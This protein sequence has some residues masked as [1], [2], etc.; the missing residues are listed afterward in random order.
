MSVE[1]DNLVKSIQ[2]NDDDEA[3]VTF[4]DEEGYGKYLDLNELYLKYIN[5]KGVDAVI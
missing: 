1:Y 4:T 5:L 2:S 3:L